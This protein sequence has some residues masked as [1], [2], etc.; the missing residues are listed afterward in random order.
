[1]ENSS[2]AIIENGSLLTVPSRACSKGSPVPTTNADWSKLV[3][4]PGDAGIKSYE[5]ARS[6]HAT[7][8]LTSKP[9][10]RCR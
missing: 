4:G 2:V 3:Q 9:E 8:V 7:Y 6:K 5:A 10:D 1:V